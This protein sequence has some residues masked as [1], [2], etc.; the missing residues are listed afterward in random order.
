MLR[1]NDTHP[2]LLVEHKDHS[3]GASTIFEKK[4]CALA[5]ILS[6]HIKG[7]LMRILPS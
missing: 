5:T 3:T 6:E 2:I 7:A 4:L 1:E